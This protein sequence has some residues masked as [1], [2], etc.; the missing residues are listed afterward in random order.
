MVLSL[1]VITKFIGQS[2]ILQV[3][4]CISQANGQSKRPIEILVYLQ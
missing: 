3:P 4:F 1:I 2:A